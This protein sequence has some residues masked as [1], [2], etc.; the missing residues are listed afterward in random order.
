L[1]EITNLVH[2]GA[3]VS[4]EESLLDH[5]GPEEIIIKEDLSFDWGAMSEYIDMISEEG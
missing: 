1:S 5:L 4:I 3:L 2:R